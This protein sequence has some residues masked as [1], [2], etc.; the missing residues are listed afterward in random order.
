MLY[1]NGSTTRPAVSS[2]YGPRAGGAFSF[3]Y[4]ADLVG[5]TRIHAIAGGLVTFAGWMNN[6]AGHTVIIDHGGGVTSVYM[7][8]ASHAVARGQRV[9]EGQHIA[10]M[11]ASGNATGPCNHLEIRVHGTSVE[12]LSYIAN[13][14][15][16]ASG[17]AAGGTSTSRPTPK[18]EE[19]EM[20]NSGVYYEK[21]KNTWV[22]LIFNTGSG[23]FHEFSN[24][25]NAGPMPSDYNNALATA[26][27]T[28]SWAKVTAGHAGV[29]KQGLAAVRRTQVV[30]VLS[31]DIEDA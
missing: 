17:S 14:L 28:P 22:Y 27:D 25:T 10:N 8:N 2:P 5:F 12:P 21:S 31:V 9:T 24:G 13:R 6:A 18:K 15:S 7:H 29:I 19:E 16:A 20:R 1:P 26:L 4:G 30:G 3:H 23:W 11:G